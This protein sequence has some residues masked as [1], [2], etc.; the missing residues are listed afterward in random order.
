MSDYLDKMEMNWQHTLLIDN[1]YLRALGAFRYLY[2]SNT[3]GKNGG[4][5]YLFFNENPRLRQDMDQ[6]V[7][8][9]LERFAIK[10]EGKLTL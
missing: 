10:K 1:E 7:M 3:S 4:V 5:S 6:L 8:D 2:R 9:R